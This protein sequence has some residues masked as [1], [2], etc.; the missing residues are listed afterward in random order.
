MGCSAGHVAK[1]VFLSKWRST[2]LGRR[3]HTFVIP[4]TFGNYIVTEFR[5]NDK[6]H[7]TL[8]TV[9]VPSPVCL[10]TLIRAK[11]RG[12]VE[13]TG[14]RRKKQFGGFRFSGVDSQFRPI[15]VF[16]WVG[17]NVNKSYQFNLALRDG[18]SPAL[19]CSTSHTGTSNKPVPSHLGKH[20]TRLAFPT[21]GESR[22][23]QAPVGASWK[24]L[25]VP[26]GC[27]QKHVVGPAFL[28]NPLFNWLEGK[29][30]GSQ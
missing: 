17:S 7:L 28:E 16:K 25:P 4:E 29:P 8:P 3:V 11:S 18:H 14:V 12:R 19:A 26:G 30:K 27:F 21:G 10:A 22:D 5:V 2:Q 13:G 1:L 23:F 9:L 24:T 20:L 6:G 15:L